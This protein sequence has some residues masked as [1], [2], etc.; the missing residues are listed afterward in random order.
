MKTLSNLSCKY[1]TLTDSKY[2]PILFLQFIMDL[3]ETTFLSKGAYGRFG[4][5]D[6]QFEFK[7]CIVLFTY[8]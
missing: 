5:T 2:Y 4:P 7:M 3:N 6:L 8:M 1:T